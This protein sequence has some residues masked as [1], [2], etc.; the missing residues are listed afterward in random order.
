MGR[1]PKNANVS[2]DDLLP[3][4]PL[5]APAV[6]VAPPE[7]PVPAKVVVPEPVPDVMSDAPKDAVGDKT[8]AYVV[9]MFANHPAVAK[10]KY[11]VWLN[12]LK[13]AGKVPAELVEVSKQV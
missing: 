10:K 12:K 5:A 13:A 11:G 6:P 7:L 3:N 9:W 1:K 4:E 8:P 2:L